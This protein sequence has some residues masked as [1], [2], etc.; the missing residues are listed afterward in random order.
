MTSFSTK[1]TKRSTDGTITKKKKDDSVLRE[2]R[3]I[4]ISPPLHILVNNQKKNTMRSLKKEGVDLANHV[5]IFMVFASIA[6]A[7]SEESAPALIQLSTNQSASDLG[8]GGTNVAPSRLPLPL[9]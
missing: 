5:K 1:K 9:T 4:P 7:S 8:E 2:K 6:L 3:E